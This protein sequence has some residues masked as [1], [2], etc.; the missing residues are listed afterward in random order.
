[1]PPVVRGAVWYPRIRV[2]SD[3]E[4]LE[5]WVAGDA[6]AG[7]AL[8]ER[9]FDAMF[10][11]FRAK[12]PMHSRDLVQRTFAACLEKRDTLRDAASFRAFLYGIARFEI[13]RLMRRTTRAA[14]E[15][16][17]SETAIHAFDP[18]PS[19]V[20]VQRQEHRLLAE[21]LR[22]IPIDLQIAVE[23]H[24]WE[25]LATAEIADVLGVPQGT[26]KSRLRRAR[27][28]L[29]VVLE[30]LTEDDALVRSTITGFDGWVR[31][32]K[33]LLGPDPDDPE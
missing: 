26:V 18:S 13:L 28:A 10:R 27:E 11:F 17:P 8:F 15:V 5:R 9:Y 25:E 7:E 6:A 31:D 4:L 33:D 29:C 23:L 3:A 14:R 12:A 30:S 1:M 19:V 32:V 2:D 20:A 24:Y 22:R 21:A 16:D